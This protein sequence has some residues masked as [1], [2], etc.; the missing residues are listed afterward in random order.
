MKSAH[1]RMPGSH[2]QA[3]C[4]GQL[5]AGLVA[6][7]QRRQAVPWRRH[8]GRLG[9]PR[10]AMRCCMWAKQRAAVQ[11]AQTLACSNGAVLQHGNTIIRAH[12]QTTAG[13][14]PGTHALSCTTSCDLEASIMRNHERFILCSTGLNTCSAA[15]NKGWSCAHNRTAP[16]TVGSPHGHENVYIDRCY[17]NPWQGATWCTQTWLTQC[18]SRWSIY[19]GLYCN[20][21]RRVTSGI[22]CTCV[23]QEV[24]AHIGQQ[25]ACNKCKRHMLQ[26][27]LPAGHPLAHTG[28]ALKDGLWRAFVQ[29][30]R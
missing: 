27:L 29:L 25:T 28:A 16:N 23:A 26:V 21:K 19:D 6:Q 8:M 13:D 3:V 14:V 18:L 7:R 12:H 1:V 4:G 5:V 30:G 11:E 22:N 9:A 2:D 24:D 17:S 10:G 20:G 15:R